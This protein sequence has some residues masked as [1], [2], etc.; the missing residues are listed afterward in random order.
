MNNISNVERIIERIN[1]GALSIM[2]RNML[3]KISILLDI[4]MSFLTNDI[5]GVLKKAY[6]ADIFNYLNS[7]NVIQSKNENIL[8]ST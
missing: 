8:T 2:L 3:D 7:V 4:F 1:I 6:L 5:F